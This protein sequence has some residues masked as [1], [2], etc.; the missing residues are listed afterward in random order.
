[1][2]RFGAVFGVAIA[3]AVFDAKGILASHAAITNGYRPALAV[4]AGLAL[5]GTVTALAVRRSA[6]SDPQADADQRPV[7]VPDAAPVAPVN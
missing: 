3:T 5:A 4:A 2:Q 6:A 7:I 1:L